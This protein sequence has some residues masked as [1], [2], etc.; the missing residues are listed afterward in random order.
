[1]ERYQV[2]L[3]AEEDLEDI[4]VFD[5]A[6]RSGDVSIPFD[7]ALLEIREGRV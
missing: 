6:K 3:E 7:Q 4:R 1:M 2:L 5:K